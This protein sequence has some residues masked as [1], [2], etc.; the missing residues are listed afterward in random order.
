[1]PAAAP[2]PRLLTRHHRL[3]TPLR[4]EEKEEAEE[5][6]EQP[7]H[8]PSEAGGGGR[9]R[10]ARAHARNPLPHTRA[11]L[12][13]TRPPPAARPEVRLGEHVGSAAVRGGGGLAPSLRGR[14]RRAGS[15]RLDGASP[16]P[17][18]A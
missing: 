8:S 7:R 6:R 9:G 17:G 18:A 12:T 2:A 10:G 11:G 16:G 14:A 13:V 5:G 3:P 4:E 15:P 1:M